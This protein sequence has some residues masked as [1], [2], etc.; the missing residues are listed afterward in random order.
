VASTVRLSTTYG[1]PSSRHG[2]PFAALP[3]EP[4][5]VAHCN[6]PSTE[7]QQQHEKNRVIG[8][9]PWSNTVKIAGERVGGNTILGFFCREETRAVAIVR[10]PA[11]PPPGGQRVTGPP[12][13]RAQNCC[14]FEVGERQALT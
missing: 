14:A 1:A 10:V 12:P 11:P 5:L 3:S 13:N 8:S 4:N 9:Q 2:Q 7:S 6:H